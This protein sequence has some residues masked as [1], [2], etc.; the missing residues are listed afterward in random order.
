M[1]SLDEALGIVLDSIPSSPV[2]EIPLENALG[3]YLAE[4]LAAPEDIPFD[5]VSAVDGYAISYHPNE[6][7]TPPSPLEFSLAGMVTAGEKP[8]FNLNPGEAARIFTGAPLPPGADAVVMQEDTRVSGGRLL[9]ASFVSPGENIRFAGEELK[10][11]GKALLEGIRLTPPAIGLLATMGHT[12]VH[13]RKP[14]SIAIVS[15]GNELIERSEPLRTGKIRDSNTPSLRACLESMGL[16]SSAYRARDDKDEIR[17]VLST[18]S[19]NNDILLVSGGMSV[20][21]YDFCREALTELGFEE[22]FWKIRIKPGKPVYLGKKENTIV[23]GIPGNPVSSLVVFHS[24][25]RPG[26]IRSMGGTDQPFFCEA[27][28]QCV[29]RKKA[30]RM[31]FMRGIAQRLDNQLL[32]STVGAQESHILSGL[33]QANCLIRLEEDRETVQPLEKVTIEWL[34]W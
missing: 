3:F 33:A 5:D 8:L 10:R 15:T 1:I 28:A 4:D 22:L 21:E 25:I 7:R 9:I 16:S 18:A 30:G 34:N 24:L 17:D 26:L 11:G 29:I 12:T 32:V 2:I 20:G 31:E 6:P 27:T 14:P 19:E 13:I 23:F